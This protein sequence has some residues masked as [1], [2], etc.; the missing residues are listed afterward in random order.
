MVFSKEFC[1]GKVSFL[2]VLQGK[3]LARMPRPLSLLTC[4][5]GVTALTAAGSSLFAEFESYRALGGRD[6]VRTAAI[7]AF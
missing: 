3:Q 5:S 2:M 4:Y 7:A 6:R 1:S